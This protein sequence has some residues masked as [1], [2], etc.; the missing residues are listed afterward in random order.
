MHA[1]NP[2]IPEVGT[3]GSELHNELKASLGYMKKKSGFS[4]PPSPPPPPPALHFFPSVLETAPWA[5]HMANEHFTTELHQ[6]ACFSVFQSLTGLLWGRWIV[7]AAA[8]TECWGSG[9]VDFYL[10]QLL[11]RCL[12]RLVILQTSTQ[13]PAAGHRCGAQPIRRCLSSHLLSSPKDRT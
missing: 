2:S 7:A 11:A 1:S 5:L 3:K 6:W 9:T 13:L 4:P 12:E 8:P 10:P